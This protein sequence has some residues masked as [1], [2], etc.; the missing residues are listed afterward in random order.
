M[1]LTRKIATHFLSF[2]C[3]CVVLV[4][5]AFTPE[6]AC[7]Q[8]PQFSMP[9]YTPLLVNPAAAGDFGKLRTHFNYSSQWKSLG[10]P[11]VTLAGSFDAH[12]GKNPEKSLLNA[13]GFGA[14]L[15]FV[16]DKQGRDGI[17]LTSA[18]GQLSYRLR[19]GKTSVLSAGLNMS[20]DQR[21][22]NPLAGQ[23]A[24]QFNG[25][26]YDPDLPSMENSLPDRESYLSLGAGV[27]YRFMK[28]ASRRNRKT[29]P[30][31]VAGIAVYDAGRVKLSET[32]NMSGDLGPRYSAYIRM[33][34]P[35]GE[36]LAAR[37]AFYSNLQN[38]V[39]TYIA[40]ANVK[41]VIVAG[42][43]FI[44]EEKPFTAGGGVFLQNGNIF[45]IN[46]EI[47]WS[48]YALAMAYRFDYSGL[49]AYT[50]GKGGFELNLRWILPFD[51]RRV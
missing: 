30:Q 21:S 1:S 29:G 40:Q 9:A 24:S 42:D 22:F 20:F 26:A 45:G 33:Q 47:T 51:Q 50:S 15:V 16:S 32:Q 37:P 49:R 35:V 3:G 13:S 17:K 11:F 36:R 48:D 39:F 44:G 41:Y 19:T 10:N 46:A 6:T 12:I 23:W 31:A 34:L 38:G 5:L 7:A 27:Q 8:G 14:G 28:E 43:T 25:I 4:S 2:F 18:K